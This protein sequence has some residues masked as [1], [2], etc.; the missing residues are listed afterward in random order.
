IKTMP[1]YFA[2]YDTTV[3]FITAE[4]MRRDHANL[5]HGGMVI[6]TGRTGANGEHSHT[7]EYRLQLDS[8][9]EFTAGVLTALARAVCR[10]QAR[11]DTGCKT[12]FD[13]PP[14]ALSPLS[15]EELRAQML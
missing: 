2:D 10:L 12:I 4:E 8:N 6:R 7:I 3:T 14:A 5:P 1:N 15:A 13:L 11:G 9:P